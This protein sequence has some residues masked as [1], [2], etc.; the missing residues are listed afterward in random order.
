MPWLLATSLFFV[1]GGGGAPCFSS[2]CLGF[3][4][5]E[6]YLACMFGLHGFSRRMIR[7][8]K[9]RSLETAP[10]KKQIKNTKNPTP[11]LVPPICELVT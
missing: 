8:C 10:Q 7:L 1:G 5:L 11:P 6:G 4:G 9:S 3:C 2:A